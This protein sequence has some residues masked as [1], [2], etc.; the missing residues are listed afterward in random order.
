MHD[1][2][3]T[4]EPGTP[5]GPPVVRRDGVANGMAGTGASFVTPSAGWPGETPGVFS[6]RTI[7]SVGAN[8]HDAGE[9]A[10]EGAA[11]GGEAFAAA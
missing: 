11:T 1:I 8:R 10:R 4:G 5:I 2:S 3:P 7:R 9:P 6:G